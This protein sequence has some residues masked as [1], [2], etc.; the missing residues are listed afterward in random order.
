[1]TVD[2]LSVG[3]LEAARDSRSFSFSSASLQP[4]FHLPFG[5]MTEKKHVPKGKRRKVEG[6]RR[7]WRFLNGQSAACCKNSS[8]FQETTPPLGTI[9]LY[10]QETP[11]AS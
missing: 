5:I 7:S 9:Q 10:L 6:G 1:M 3:R 4:S 8:E 11:A 2:C